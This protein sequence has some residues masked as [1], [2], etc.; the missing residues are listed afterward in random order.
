[1]IVAASF[2]IAISASIIPIIKSSKM[3]VTEAI[4]VYE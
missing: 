3:S 4:G 2:V 1:M